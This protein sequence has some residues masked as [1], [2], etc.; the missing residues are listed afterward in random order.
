M[1]IIISVFIFF[2]SLLI[3]NITALIIPIKISNEVEEKG[4]DFSIHGESIN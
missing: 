3:Y 4:L 1:L 2:G